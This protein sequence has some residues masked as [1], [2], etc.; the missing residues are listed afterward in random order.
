[1]LDTFWQDSRHAIRA[2]RNDRGFAAVTALSLAMGIG[3]N[4]AIFSLINAVMLR[5]LPVRHPEEL[6]QVTAG[7]T[8]GGYFSNPVWEQIRDRQDAF[9]GI[10][11]YCRWAFNLASGGEAR[12]VNG[13]YVS[14]QF[15]DTLGVPAVF[16][17]TFT[18]EDDRRGC[19]GR[20]VLTYGFWQRE[21][22][23]Q[24][25]LL[26]KTIA[27]DRH[28][29]EIVGVAARGFTG[30]EVGA[31]LDVMVPLCAEKILHGDTTLL[32]ADP[33]GRWLRILGRPSRGTSASQASARLR[34]LSPEVFRA[35]VQSKWSS[36]DREKWLRLSLAAQTA[37]NGLS[38][39]REDYHQA[40][41]VL[42]SIA[43]IVL[44]IGCANMSNLLL[45]RGAVRQREIAIR[46][47]LG[48]G[49][50]R[51]V[52]QM[53]TE[54]LLLSF[55]GAGLGVLVAAGGT[56]L[57]VKFLDV[58]LDLTPDLRVL[59]FTAGIAILTGLLFGLAPAWRGSRADPIAAMKAGSR[60]LVRGAGSTAG[61]LL[62]MGQVALSMVLVAGAG[63]LLSTFLRLAWM[64]PGFDEDRVLLTSINLRGAGYTP[65]R[66]NAVFRQILEKVRG[67]PG[68]RAASLSD[69]TPMLHAVR[70]H[71]VLIEGYAALP[72]QDSRI[73]F[74]AV[75]DGYFTTIGTQLIAGRD[76]N[77][78]DTS[79]SPA[80]AIVNQTVVKKYFRGANPI[81][82]SFRIRRGDTFGDAVEIVGVVKDAKYN[83][84]RKEI[85]PTAYTM[86]GQNE[87]AFPF[88]NIEVRPAGGAPGA[89]IAG[90][91]GAIA[92]VDGS[93][94][95]E[96]T[97][98]ADQVGKTLE[99]EQLLAT[100]AS[101][102]GGLALLLAVIGLYGVTSYNVARRRSEIGIR[103]ALGAETY[104]ILRM[105]MGEAAVLI[106]SA[107][108]AG[109]VITLAA[110]GLVASFL[111][112]VRPND[113]LTL[114]SAAVVLAAA[115][116]AASYLPARRASL[117]DPMT[118]LREE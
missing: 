53:L 114:F 95:I 67:L 92:S 112:G 101:F 99:R 23:G 98:L 57:L 37:A 81:G 113:P 94:S 91:K 32:D 107:I 103:M 39:L 8:G 61:K 17:R 16:G 105:V 14:G 41:F 85:P 49:R 106:G 96:F 56:G 6:L 50:G 29:F 36:Q 43:G 66:R 70:I 5:N 19:V 100:L 42:I 60:G 74:N 55:L 24:S 75:S 18:R 102:F 63:L 64:D 28:A 71:E 47:A 87:Y 62:V 46:I 2:L 21:Y 80:V 58:S 30:T 118:S 109:L 45:A 10:L 84:L 111:Y 77:R 1:M 68:I 20:A 38:S 13:E 115:A 82:K 27:I 25:D 76:F 15:F 9:S 11:A 54:S 83:D 89:L 34:A 35:T 110:A 72:E 104:K 33:A 108:A 48:S 79:G 31:S 88:T 117:L 93:A 52:R 97:T 59:G 40:L 7:G 44:L 78:H 3:A 69:F 12:N 90:V 86:W 73:Y 22:G 116:G 51:L 4:T 65:E 26:G